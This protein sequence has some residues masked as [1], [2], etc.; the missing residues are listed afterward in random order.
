M[1][2]L[3]RLQREVAATDFRYAKVYP[4]IVKVRV[5]VD[6]EEIMKWAMRHSLNH[7][8]HFVMFLNY[9]EG[10]NDRI[11]LVW[12]VR[13]LSKNENEAFGCKLTFG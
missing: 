6:R 8:E 3:E 10:D 13:F 1:T 7:H 4:L 12:W 9:V 11:E 5:G 2:L